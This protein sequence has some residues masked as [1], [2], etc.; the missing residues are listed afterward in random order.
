MPD[1]LDAADCVLLLAG[2]TGI[3]GAISIADW[4]VSRNSY[5]N[6]SNESLCLIW[7]VRDGKVARLQE[8]QDLQLRAEE[9]PNFKLKVHV[10]GE[11]GRLNVGAEIDHFISSGQTGDKRL[12]VYASGTEAFLDDA[13]AAC[14]RHKKSL[15]IR[16]QRASRARLDWHIANYSK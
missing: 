1:G 11:A 15:G 6:L 14:V 2:G 5:R 9:C 8:V 10:S 13:E 16:K 12:W 7:T 4:W 3:T